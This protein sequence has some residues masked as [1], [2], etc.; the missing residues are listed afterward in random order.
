MLDLV[1]LFLITL[2]AAFI[3]I[4]I[5]RA[6][7]GWQ[8]FRQPLV[9]QQ[10]EPSKMSLRAQLEYSLISGPKQKAKTVRL[11]SPKNGVKA[12]WGW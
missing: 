3:A 2:L 1:T 11:L 4:R 9:G 6:I 8:G 10:N 7:V 5:Y 12:P